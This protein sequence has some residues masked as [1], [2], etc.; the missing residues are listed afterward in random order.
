[1]LWK[2]IIVGD[3]ERVLIAKNGRFSGILEQGQHR[4]FVAPG[5]TLETERHNLRGLVFESKWTDYLAQKR[6]DLVSRH[7]MRVETSDAQVAMVYVDGKLKEV[8]LPAKRVLYWRGL[9]EVTAEV[10]DVIAQPEIPAI[11]LPALER[12][13]QNSHALLTTVEEAK[14]GLLFIDN[15]L[16]RTLSPGKYGFWAVTG[17]PRVEIIDLRRQT[18]EIAGQK[19]LSRDKVALRVNI[20]ADYQVRNAV[21]AKNVVTNFEGHLYRLLQL[22]VRQALGK[23]TLEEV[24]AAKTEIDEDAVAIV[25]SEMS[26]MGMEVGAVA[27]KDIILPGDMREIMNQVVSAEKQAQANLIRRREETAATCSLLNTA[28][29]LEDNPILVR[30]KELETLE[31]LVEKVDRLTVT[32]GFEGLLDNLIELKTPP[33]AKSR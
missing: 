21:K 10:V 16:V 24:L 8:L 2:R 5:V 11:K 26:S 4:I 9:V 28:K 18:L 13:G 6:P 14:T 32:G 30:L 31:K 27:L 15:R 7:F 29:L 25:R 22:T 1:M 23:K 3:Q 33:M 20:L 19:I 12:L 17:S